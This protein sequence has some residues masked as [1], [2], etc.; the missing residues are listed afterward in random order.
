M[1]HILHAFIGKFIVVYFDD[2]LIYSKGLDEYIRHLRQVLD[3]L[4]NE[5]LYANLKKYDFYMDKIVFLGYVVSV[6]G[7]KMDEV[8]LR[9]YKNDLHLNQLH[10]LEV[11]IV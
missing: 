8:R 9:L 6:K 1:N 4:R 5:S 7:M 2:I 10:K 11:F 3:V